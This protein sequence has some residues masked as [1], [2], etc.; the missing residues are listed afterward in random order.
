MVPPSVVPMAWSPSDATIRNTS[1]AF[2]LAASSRSSA[3]RASSLSLAC[4]SADTRVAL[5]IWSSQTRS[6][7]KL[8]RSLWPII[9]W[10]QALSSALRQSCSFESASFSAR[11]RSSSA[12]CDTLSFDSCCR[13]S[14]TAS[15]SARID[16]ACVSTPSAA[17]SPDVSTCRKE[18]K[19]RD[20]SARLYF[21]CP[22]QRLS[23][24]DGMP[25][26]A[27]MLNVAPTV[28]SLQRVATRSKKS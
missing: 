5:S 1:M 26:G 28:G 15:I 19:P 20:A 4:S 2:S 8:S 11:M 12:F 27:F 25:L 13:R 22:L 9:L 18:L 24:S 6:S 14:R 7:R 10:R 23:R 17:T 16:T 3:S 21:C